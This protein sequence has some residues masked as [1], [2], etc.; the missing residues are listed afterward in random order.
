MIIDIEWSDLRDNQFRLADYLW[1]K[2]QFDMFRYRS[3]LPTVSRIAN[4]HAITIT[5]LD[6][7]KHITGIRFVLTE[8]QYTFLQIKYSGTS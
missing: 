1:R 6:D 5:P 3:I 2:V 8:C 4:D 7:G